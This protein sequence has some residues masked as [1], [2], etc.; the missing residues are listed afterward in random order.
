MTYAMMKKEKSWTQIKRNHR[1][2]TIVVKVES[3]VHLML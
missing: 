1:S 2:E 3:S